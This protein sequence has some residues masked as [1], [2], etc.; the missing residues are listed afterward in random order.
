M[1]SQSNFSSPLINEDLPAGPQLVFTL[2]NRFFRHQACYSL[3]PAKPGGQ[4]DR[5]ISLCKYKVVGLSCMHV[6]YSSCS[7]S[8]LH[9]PVLS[10][11]APFLLLHAPALSCVA[12]PSLPAYKRH[13]H[14]SACFSNAPTFFL[15]ASPSPVLSLCATALSLHATIVFL[16]A[17]VLT[18]HARVLSLTRAVNAPNNPINLIIP[19]LNHTPLPLKKSSLTKSLRASPICHNC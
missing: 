11:N 4:A 13:L 6:S 14:A 3:L 12:P 17:F 16:H 10:L 9:A 1:L 7:W 5:V 18:L 8:L 15:H 19:E 2:N